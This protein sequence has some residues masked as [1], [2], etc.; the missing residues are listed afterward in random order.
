MIPCLTNQMSQ[1][2]YLLLVLLE[3]MSWKNH[4]HQTVLYTLLKSAWIGYAEE[5]RVF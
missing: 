2:L 5:T 4:L 3:G 1:N